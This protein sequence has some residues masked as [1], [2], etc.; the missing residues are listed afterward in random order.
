MFFQSRNSSFVETLKWVIAC[1]SRQW[2]TIG[3]CE[4]KSLP[5]DVGIFTHI[6]ICSDIFRHNEVYWGTTPVYSSI[7]R[8]LVYSK[9]LRIQNQRHSQNSDIFRALSNIYDGTMERFVQIGS[10]YNNFCNVSFPRSLLYEINIFF[11]MH[12]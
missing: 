1:S 10:S 2:I 5:A 8:T 4:T 9:P 7:F 6:A 11:S 12:V 3:E